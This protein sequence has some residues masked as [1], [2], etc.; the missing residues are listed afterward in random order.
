MK[1]RT[2]KSIRLLTKIN[3]SITRMDTL[4]SVISDVVHVYSHDDG[5][6][7]GNV[8]FNGETFHAKYN[9]KLGTWV[10]NPSQIIKRQSHRSMR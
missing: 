2:T 7:T 6:L 3:Q 10:Y 8:N 5:S 9:V 4:K 1:V